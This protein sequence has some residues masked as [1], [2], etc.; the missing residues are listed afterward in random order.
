MDKKN[1]LECGFSI[2][3][4]ATFIVLAEFASDILVPSTIEDGLLENLSALFFAAASVFFFIAA[5]KISSLY[6]GGWKTIAMTVAW[7]LLMFVFFGEE[8]SW[9]QRIFDF[10]T[11]EKLSEINLQNEF[12]IHNIDIVD[13]AFG[14][15]YRYLTLMMLFFSIV[16]PAM[17]Y[18]PL[19]RKALNFTS[20]P[21]ATH[22]IALL[23]LAAYIYGKYYHVSVPSNAA[24]EVREFLFSLG[25]VWFSMICAFSPQRVY[26]KNTD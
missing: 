24:S 19:G 5:K 7:A 15:K 22:G 20:F 25:L 26:V 23:V 2:L 21:A 16:F 18:F 1:S 9:G 14:G 17:K 3:V 11:P 13:T 4:I 8:I 12:N 6:G 10:S